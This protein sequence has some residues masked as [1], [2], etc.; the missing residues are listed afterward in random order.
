MG[1]EHNFLG[2]FIRHFVGKPGLSRT[3]EMASSVAGF[4]ANF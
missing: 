2:A 4:I 3:W 1:S